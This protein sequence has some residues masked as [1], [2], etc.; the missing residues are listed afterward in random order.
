MKF[1]GSYRYFS[2]ILANFDPQKADVIFD[3]PAHIIAEAYASKVIYEYR[4]PPKKK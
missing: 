4:D 3:N 2:M 1:L